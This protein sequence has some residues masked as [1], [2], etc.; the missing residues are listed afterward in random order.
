ME[1]ILDKTDLTRLQDVI[2]QDIPGFKVGFKNESLT[3]K[4]LGF[5]ACPFNSSFMSR[6]V[7]TWGTV[8]YFP[9]REF[10]WGDPARSFR[11]LAHEYVHL[12]D[13]KKHWAF[14]LSYMF[15][16]V[17]ALLPMLVYAVLAW[18][19]SWLVLLPFLGYV[20]GCGAAKVHKALFWITMPLLLGGVAILAS[21]LTGWFSLVLLGSVLF[22]APWPAYWR[23]RWE[24]RGYGMNMALAQWLYSFS[25]RHRESITRQFTGPA[26]LCMC[27]SRSK[28]ENSL[29]VFCVRAMGADLQEDLPYGRVFSLLR[30]RARCLEKPV[31]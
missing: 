7:T 28:V 17:L 2:K 4:V 11:I 14:K 9:T 27:W 15:P 23:T 30:G 8:V 10:F 12:W 22:L 25:P 3:M 6:Y 5:L 13:A 1:P 16:Q 24:L 18:P 26:Y 20:L 29:D 31:G 19:H 21:Y